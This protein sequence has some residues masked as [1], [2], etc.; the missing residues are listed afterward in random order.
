MVGGA[1]AWL[2]ERR[3]GPD[4]ERSYSVNVGRRRRGRCCRVRIFEFDADGRLRARIEARAGRV[5]DDGRWTLTDDAARRW[6]ARPRRAAARAGQ[7]SAAQWPR[8]RCDAAWWPPPCC[9]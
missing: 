9:R 8:A 7:R 3:H 1:G 4:G 6:P 2:K 5:D